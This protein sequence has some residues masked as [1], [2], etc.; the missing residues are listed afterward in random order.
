MSKKLQTVIFLVRH[1]QTDFP[2]S[3]DPT[4]D[5]RRRLTEKGQS[6]SRRNGRYLKAFRPTAI[7]SSPL[8]RT[9]ETSSIIK[10]LAE[11]PGEVITGQDLYEIYDNDS[12]YSIGKCLPKFFQSIIAKHAGEQVVC[13]SHQDVIETVLRSYDVS[14]Q[15]AEFPC[16][17]GEMYRLVFAGDVF[18]QATKLTPANHEIHR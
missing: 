2:Y 11:I 1:G 5:D 12:F 9:I 17:M 7:Y 6:Q 8:H 14:E 3:N 13:V 15:E 16:L 4:V 10:E 18:V